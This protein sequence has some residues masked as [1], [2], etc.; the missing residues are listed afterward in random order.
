MTDRSRLEALVS[1]ARGE[2]VT[3]DALGKSTGDGP[4]VGL[5]EADEQPQY[6]LRGRLLDIIDRAAAESASDRRKRKVA[7][8]GADLHT[9]VTDD[10]FL[11]VV[12]HSDGIEQLSVP[13][14]SVS[15]VDT[16]GAPGASR[17]VRVF[18]EA[19]AYYIDTAQSAESE[20]EAVEEFTADHVGEATAGESADETLDM[21]ER[22][23]DLNE[24]GALTDEEFERKKREL[25]DRL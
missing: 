4:L 3:A 25:L 23:A 21:I 24:G 2:S 6:I 1:A 11:I 9:L 13:F 12:P 18:T 14:S 8:S 15:Q 22:L 17:R 20:V 7:A 16:E 19:T 10:R 5:L